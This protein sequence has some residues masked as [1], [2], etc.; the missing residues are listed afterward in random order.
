MY[1]ATN[2]CRTNQKTTRKSKEM[3]FCAISLLLLINIHVG[4]SHHSNIVDRQPQLYDLWVS[5]ENIPIVIGIRRR[6]KSGENDIEAFFYK[7]QARN[8]LHRRSWWFALGIFGKCEIDITQYVLIRKCVIRYMT[9][10]G[11]M[12]DP[13]FLILLN[14]YVCKKTGKLYLLVGPES[15]KSQFGASNFRQQRAQWLFWNFIGNAARWRF[16]IMTPSNYRRGTKCRCCIV[17]NQA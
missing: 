11:Q 2:V 9:E 5:R 7:V 13:T 1:V 10:R 12:A 3:H 14:N 6:Y 15:V 17:S 4:R 8:D 16:T